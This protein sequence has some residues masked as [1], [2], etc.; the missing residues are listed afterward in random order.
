[1]TTRFKAGER[2]HRDG[3]QETSGLNASIADERNPSDMLAKTRKFISECLKH[4]PTLFANGVN[5]E[6]SIGTTV[7]DSAQ[8]L[9]S[10]DFSP[11][12]IRELAVLGISL[13]FT[14]YP[15][16]DGTDD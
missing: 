1:V 11:N 9:T 2:R 15:T 8:Y 16:S 6:L 13:N 4:G 5:A 10:V 12:D 7:G 3:I 14:A